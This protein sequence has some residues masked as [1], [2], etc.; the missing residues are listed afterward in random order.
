ML[1]EYGIV[2]PPGANVVARHLPAL[3]E[4]ADNG[5]PMLARHLLAELKAA[6][7]QLIERIERCEA[8]LKAWHAGNA[9]SQRLAGIP[10]S[11]Y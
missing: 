5:L 1:S 6:H 4:D 2:L 10:A 9:V 11:A 3:L 8:Q 7:H